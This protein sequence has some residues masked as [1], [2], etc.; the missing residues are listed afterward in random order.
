MKKTLIIIF[1]L[2]IFGIAIG[3]AILPHG[4]DVAMMQFHDKRYD[5]ALTAYEGEASKGKMTVDGVRN[6]VDIYLQNGQIDEAIVVMER[7]IKDNPD[8][9]EA[10]FRLGTLY[11]YAQRTDDYKRNL[12][13]I[14]KMKPSAEV[15]N[16]LANIYSKDAQYKE[17]IEAMKESLERDKQQAFQSYTDL[18]YLQASQKQYKDAIISLM[19]IRTQFPDRMKFEHEE[20][21]VNLLMDDSQPDEAFKEAK[22]W[23]DAHPE[24]DQIA[25]LANIIH[26]KGSAQKALELITPYEAL[27]DKSQSLMSERVSLYI[28]N[29]REDEAYAI[30][31]KLHAE[32]T[33]PR[34]LY[35]S[36]IDQ[37]IKHGDQ[38]LVASMVKGLDLAVLTETQ[39]V[40][41]VELAQTDNQ[42][43][44]LKTINERK[45]QEMLD[46][47]PLFATMLAMANHD[48]DGTKRAM[49]LSKTEI[50]TSAKM[51]LARACLRAKDA[52]CAVAI[53]DGLPKDYA[54]SDLDIVSLAELYMISG[55]TSQ[56]FSFINE[57]RRERP[58]AN[59]TKSWARLAAADGQSKELL[60]WLGAEGKSIKAK[61]VEELYYIAANR[62]HHALAT[63][64]AKNLHARNN[65]AESRRILAHSYIKGQQYELA[66]PLLRDNKSL[67]SR[68]EEAYIGALY[69][70]SKKN[71]KFHDEL[72]GYY[73]QLLAS[74]KVPDQR[75]KQLVYALVDI[76]R[77]DIAL[78]FIK[79]YAYA[80]GGSWG[81]LYE[82]SMKKSSNQKELLNYRL[83]RA[84]NPKA[85]KEEVRQIAYNLLEEGYQDNALDIFKRLAVGQ[86]VESKDAQQAM[87]LMGPRPSKENINWLADRAR[88]SKGAEQTGWFEV[89]SDHG[90]SGH[91]VAIIDKNQS[92]LSSRK[93]VKLYMQALAS[94]GDR[95]RMAE[96]IMERVGSEKDPEIVR[97]YARF[98]KQNDQI[99]AS[100]TAYTRLEA[101][102]PDDAEA[103]RSLG[104][105]AFSRSNY[106]EAR[107]RFAKFV[108]IRNAQKGSGR[109]ANDPEAYEGEYEAFFYTG[110]IM[111]NE[112]REKD[113]NK[114]YQHTVNLVGADPD[115]S[116]GAL[117]IAS[118]AYHRMGDEKNAYDV[119]GKTLQQNPNDMILRA[120]YAFMLIESKKYDEA[121]K[122][123]EEG[124]S[125]IKESK[126][127]RE[128]IASVNSGFVRYFQLSPDNRELVLNLT[129]PSEKLAAIKPLAKKK[130]KAIGYTT[131]GFDTVVMASSQ[132][133]ALEVENQAESTNIYASRVGR[134]MQPE[135]RK[136]A[137]LRLELLSARI[138][139][140]TGH[141]ARAV[142]NLAKLQEKYPEDPQLLGFSANANYFAGN[143]RRALEMTRKAQSQMPENEDIAVLQRDISNANRGYV[144][145][146]ADWKHQGKN[147]E[148]IVGLSGFNYIQPFTRI[149]GSFEN[150]YADA[151]NI[152]R[153]DGRTGDFS[154]NKQRLEAYVRHDTESGIMLQGSLYANN[155]TP[156]AGVKV[157]MSNPLGETQLFGELRR[158]YWEFIEGVL[159][160]ATRDRV[161]FDHLIKI[162][163]DFYATIGAAY[164]NYNVRD[165]SNVARTVSVNGSLRK[166]VYKDR[167]LT[168]SL[169]YNFDA[170]YRRSHKTA[171]DSNGITFSRF[172]MRTREVHMVDV[173]LSY[174]LSNFTNLS[175]FLGYAYDRFGGH[176]PVVGAD[177]T[178][179]F[180]ENLEG[181]LHA[182]HGLSLGDSEESVSKVGGYMK[183]KF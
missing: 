129:A 162:R 174:D 61:E 135:M 46:R 136:Q 20:L 44:L 52:D 23:I 40:F 142:E 25:R 94:S 43:E 41:L 69:K 155:D 39:L 166:E 150:D 72:A 141:Q 154:K 54:F 71:K 158:P 73:K 151:S 117:S 169:G 14:S 84:N 139:L 134:F 159:D 7:F 113:A 59:F 104:L 36:L 112:H 68:D 128:L 161:G 75:K 26:Y 165:Y 140:E 4:Q 170:E 125:E 24:P 178:H 133:Y 177:L 122:V 132:N 143:W 173:S 16:E 65:N 11:Q 62:G 99:T 19:T 152:R 156:G 100:R 180:A 168:T 153:A 47:M 105:I 17:Q 28:A 31:K 127:G 179:Q 164:N 88:E 64:L 70:A 34:D 175:G 22:M 149:G 81:S 144:K 160:D 92:L 181:N 29:G 138:D 63:E 93:N 123:L 146:A 77:G 57:K 115:P 176:G 85:S 49:A 45:T 50:T 55:R 32:N 171:V 148:Y 53:M 21:L 183:Y 120:D 95:K 131:I 5:E 78:P 126:A 102:L 121:R 145:A 90:G 91:V 110:E 56:G 124:K 167:N 33:L 182:S 172:P 147:N 80:E 86:S 12:E 67:S 97:D 8:S 38:S 30:M 35:Q 58:T 116:V 101:L 1:V 60:P 15:L 13:E 107:R 106:S 109:N 108:D 18:A 111:R 2:A 79:Q 3:M 37:A 118:Q 103:N 114:F 87:F 89:L 137:E 96:V 130:H 9:V 163:P 66:V 27:A 48:A 119:M 82:Q 10:R 42:P 51:Q 6:L 76:G 98:A 83:S 157:G 74:K